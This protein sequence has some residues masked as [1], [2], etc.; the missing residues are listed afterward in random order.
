MGRDGNYRG[1]PRGI[2]G[3]S[4]EKEN[5]VHYRGGPVG[6]PVGTRGKPRGV[7]GCRGNPPY[8][9]WRPARSHGK[10]RRMQR[11]AVLDFLGTLQDIPTRARRMPWELPHG[12]PI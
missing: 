6:C 3:K 5:A 12:I 9:T 1:I 10:S 11:N 4:H 2:S 7:V 8:L